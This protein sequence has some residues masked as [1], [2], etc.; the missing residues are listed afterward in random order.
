MLEQG[1]GI[2]HL[3]VV[4]GLQAEVRA[5]VDGDLVLLGEHAFSISRL[6]R[7]SSSVK[8]TA[9]MLFGE[10]SMVPPSG[11]EAGLTGARRRV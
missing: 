4:R 6:S 11:E 10:M 8:V 1:D 5:L 7:A 9:V 2:A 3:L